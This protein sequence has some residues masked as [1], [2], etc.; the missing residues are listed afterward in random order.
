MK[1]ILGLVVSTVAFFV[2]VF[3]IRRS[4]DDTGIPPGMT[5]SLVVLIGA[6]AVSY[7]VAFLVDWLP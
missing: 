5:R 7:A 6:S 2:A 1:L 4:L 3:Y